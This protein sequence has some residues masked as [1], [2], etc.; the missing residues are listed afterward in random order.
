MPAVAASIKPPVVQG[1]VIALFTQGASKRSIAKQLQID[2]ATVDRILKS[3][4]QNQPV[5]ASRVQQLVPLAYDAL[6]KGLR[7]KDARLGLDF[8][9]TTELAERRGDTFTFTG[10]NVLVQAVGMLPSTTSTAESTERTGAGATEAAAKPGPA[11]V[12]LS[13]HPNFSQFSLAE[14]EAEVARRKSQLIEAE[15]SDA[16]RP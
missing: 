15:V 16:V 7:D 3:Y 13:L 11:E 14:L 1:D 2:R 4:G 10:D 12:G 8:L 5:S 6:E 9:K